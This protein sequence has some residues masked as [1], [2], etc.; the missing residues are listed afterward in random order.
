MSHPTQEIADTN[1]AR[2]LR[3]FAQVVAH[4]LRNPLS[5]VKIALQTMQRQ[6]DIAPKQA[7][8][9]EIALREVGTIDRVLTEILDWSR[10][11]APHPVR[12]AAAD[13]LAV[14]SARVQPDLAEHRVRLVATQDGAITFRADRELSA[15]AV[16]DLLRNA[17]QASAPG[18]EVHLSIGVTPEGSVISVTDSGPGIAPEE[19]EQVFEPFFSRRARGVGL[20]LPRAR[21]IAQAHGGQLRLEPVETGGTR[22][23]IVFPDDRGPAAAGEPGMPAANGV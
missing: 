23:V 7:T 11:P 19:R 21:R 18:A 13:L 3:R 15:V 12:M 14:V 6:A 22:A 8:R 17:I 9:L 1:E 20:G 5:A 16:A 4:E 10:P 2:N